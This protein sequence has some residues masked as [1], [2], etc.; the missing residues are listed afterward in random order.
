MITTRHDKPILT[1]CRNNLRKHKN[2]WITFFRYATETMWNGLTN[3]VRHIMLVNLTI[4]LFSVTL[5]IVPLC[6]KLWLVSDHYA[7]VMLAEI[8]PLNPRY[9]PNESKHFNILVLLLKA[10][11]NNAENLKCVKH[12]NTSIVCQ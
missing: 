7:R 9:H 8:S 4:M 11:N 2:S 10:T 1:R 6:R 5:K 12:V 3:W